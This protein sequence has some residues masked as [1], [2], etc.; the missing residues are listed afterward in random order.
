MQYVYLIQLIVDA[1]GVLVLLK[2][3]NQDLSGFKEASKLP[4]LYA[5][6]GDSL[7]MNELQKFSI[8]FLLKLMRRTCEKQSERIKSFLVQYKAATIMKKIITK[9]NSSQEIKKL[10]AKVCKIQVKFMTK[11]WRQSKLKYQI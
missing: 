1:N 11:K 7:V 9:F 3:L 8:R 5:G 2:F 6:F 10:A 4:I